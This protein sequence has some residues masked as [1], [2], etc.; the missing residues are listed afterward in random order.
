MINYL[1]QSSLRKYSYLSSDF[2]NPVFYFFL[3][4]FLTFLISCSPTERFT[5]NEERTDIATTTNESS[6]KSS[7]LRV[8]LSDLR[9]NEAIKVDSPSYL[10]DEDKKLILVESGTR[11]N[12]FVINGIINLFFDGNNLAAKRFFLV[13]AENDGMVKINGYNYR[14]KI[15]ISSSENSIHLI[16]IISLEDYVKGV[17]A[18]EMPT[19]QGNEN[20]EALKALAVCIRT[21]AVKK[22]QNGNIYFDLYA[23]TR[24]QV[25][26]GLDS[27]NEITNKAVDE[28]KSMVLKY[29]NAIATL[30]YHSTCG[31]YTESSENVF[32]KEAL[33]YLQ[34]IKDGENP[35]CKISPRFKWEEKYSKEEII[36]RLKD[37]GLLNDD[38]YSLE[39]FSVVGRYKSGRVSEL[40]IR[41]NDEND[42][43]KI[44]TLKGNEIRSILRTSDNKSILWSTMF[45]VSM[46]SNSITLTGNGFGHG[47]GL[48]QW[49]AIAMSKKGKNF[50]EI[51]QHYYPGTQLSKLND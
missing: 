27:E 2:N 30:Y 48:C 50:D 7:E 34:S 8:L 35:Y 31:G 13:S 37:Y 45:D 22:L 11:V 32:T 38:Y 23:D 6:L 47:V 26:G 46:N 44:L 1:H 36:N 25:Y 19:G 18:K 16:N 42:N 28:T 39:D 4:S 49:G 51:L 29:S 40:E 21:Y 5:K 14:G 41:V 24:D 15:Q 3:F 17:L 20:F 10:Y 43:E 33:P 9:A 12:C